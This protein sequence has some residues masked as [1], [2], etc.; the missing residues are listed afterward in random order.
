V[1]FKNA[2]SLIPFLSLALFIKGT[3]SPDE[4]VLEGL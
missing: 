4:Y 1:A 3:G 2:T